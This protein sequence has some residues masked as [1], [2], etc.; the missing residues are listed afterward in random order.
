M[1]N[2]FILR[3][4]WPTAILFLTAAAGLMAF[5]V[6][7]RLSRRSYRGRLL[8]LGNE[9]RPLLNA[10][11]ADSIEY[12]DVL[13]QLRALQR[14]YKQA[15]LEKWL[16]ADRDLSPE[17]VPVLRRLCEDLGLIDLWQRRL[18][19]ER[20]TGSEPSQGIARG[21]SHPLSFVL[22]AESAE[23]LGIIRHR[24][25]WRILVEALTDPHITVR[26]VA[27]RALA[28]IQEPES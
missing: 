14:Q 9:V 26:A 1:S 3:F 12:G 6:L 27:S 5:A 28:R 2:S 13:S 23:N 7:R 24:P 10:L 19:A 21:R 16:M 18:V 20:S 17:K 4:A 25:S 15:A 11:L 22:R 8:D